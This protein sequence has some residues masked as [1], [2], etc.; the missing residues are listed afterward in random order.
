M[1][2]QKCPI[3]QGTGLTH[4][5]QKCS[6]CNGTKLISEITGLPPNIPNITCSS[7]NPTTDFK[8]LQKGSQ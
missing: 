6:T 5:G 4:L 3:C 7:T 1:S 8:D 2:Y